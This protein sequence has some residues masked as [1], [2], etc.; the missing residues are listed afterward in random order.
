M[1]LLIFFYD[2]LQAF[3]TL[4]E[5][6][7]TVPNIIAPNWCLPFEIMCDASDFS[8]GAIMGQRRGKYFQVIY[9]ASQ[10]LNDAQQNYTTTEKKLVALVFS[11]DKFYSYL[12]GAKTIVYRDHSALKYL[13]K[14]N[15]T[16][17]R[18]IR[19]IL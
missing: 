14:K 6:L 19:W 7:T 2:C 3:K 8:I 18:L 15:D 10:T 5:K 12:I 1:H 4:K 17:P 16:K 9:Y 11:S 13:L